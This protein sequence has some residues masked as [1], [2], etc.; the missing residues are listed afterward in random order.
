M[1]TLWVPPLKY[2]TCESDLSD[3]SREMD[4][5]RQEHAI[6][7]I[8]WKVYGCGPVVKFRISYRDTVIYLKFYVTEKTVL[9]QHTQNNAMVCEDSCVEFFAAP[10]DDGVYYNLEFNCIGTCRIGA[11]RSRADNRLIDPAIIETVRRESTLGTRPFAERT[12]PC[13]WTL[14]AAIPAAVFVDHEI[15]TLKNA[16]FRGNFYKCGDK[17]STP[18]Y[19]TWNRIKTREPDFHRPEFFGTI[20]F[21]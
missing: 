18:H 16:T 14:V 13:T 1:K 7:E 20:R 9:A 10:A 3:I 15:A 2:C 11:G 19:L 5:L 8:N 12:G 21:E 6:G 4:A 17:L